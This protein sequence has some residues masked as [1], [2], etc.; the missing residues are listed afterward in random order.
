MKA[1]KIK[2]N[3]ILGNKLNHETKTLHLK[4]TK[5]LLKDIKDDTNIW[6]DMLFQG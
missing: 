2:S 3:Q 4:I 5:H 6:K 1:P